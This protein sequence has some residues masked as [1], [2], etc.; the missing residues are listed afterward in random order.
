MRKAEY[1]VKDE[2]LASVEL[3]VPTSPTS[4]TPCGNASAIEK[5]LKTSGLAGRGRV[6][7]SHT[8]RHELANHHLAKGR[9]TRLVETYMY[10]IRALVVDDAISSATSTTHALRVAYAI[11]TLLSCQLLVWS[12]DPP[13]SDVFMELTFLP[14]SQQLSV[15]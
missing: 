12:T 4:R 6:A 11:G 8:V 13:S 14:H 3:S 10:E 1:F 7:Y 5:S 2:D 15:T 9:G